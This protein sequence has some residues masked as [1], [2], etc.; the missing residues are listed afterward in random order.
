MIIMSTLLRLCNLFVVFF[1][2]SYNPFVS[3]LANGNLPKKAFVEY[4]QQDSFYLEQALWM[5][6]NF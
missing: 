4:I 3:G 6:F 1:I 5:E 2:A